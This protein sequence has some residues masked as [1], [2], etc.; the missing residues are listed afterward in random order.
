MLP[1]EARAQGMKCSHFE[2]RDSGLAQELRQAL[3]HFIGSLVCECDRTDGES[4]DMTIQDE[5]SDARSKDLF[6]CQLL[7]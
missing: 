1:Q 6:L 7:L 4:W 3:S 2:L 5:M